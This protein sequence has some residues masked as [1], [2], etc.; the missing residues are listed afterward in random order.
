MISE[1]QGLQ[2]DNYYNTPL[3][4]IMRFLRT[5]S[6]L[7]VQISTDE[8]ACNSYVLSVSLVSKLIFFVGCI[9]RKL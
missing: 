3:V 1:S 4:K 9:C 2:D 7:M 8:A 5:F 6:S